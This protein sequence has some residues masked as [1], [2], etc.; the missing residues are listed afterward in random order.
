MIKIRYL[1]CSERAQKPVTRMVCDSRIEAENLL[2]ELQKREEVDPEDAY[3]TVEVGPESD[4]WRF[5][6]AVST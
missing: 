4:A 6:A 2:A 5:L 3:W 1:V